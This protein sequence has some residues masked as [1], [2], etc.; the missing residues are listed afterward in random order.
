MVCTCV[1]RAFLATN[2]SAFL[3]IGFLSAVGG[4]PAAM[5]PADRA[6]SSSSAIALECS[7]DMAEIMLT[8]ETDCGLGAELCFA[9]CSM[10]AARFGSLWSSTPE[11]PEDVADVGAAVAT[12]GDAG[13]G[14][15]RASAARFQPALLLESMPADV[16]RSTWASSWR[17]ICIASEVS[18]S[19]MLRSVLD[20]SC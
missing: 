14:G 12:V 10:S 9:A 6:S 18:F 11:E 5:Q 19:A 8:L 2:S 4:M 13:P 1:V 15:T 17:M 16:M 20:I 7:F 3:S